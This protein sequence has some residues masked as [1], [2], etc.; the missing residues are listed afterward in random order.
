MSPVLFSLFL[1][2]LSEFISHAYNGLNNVSDMAHI[3]LSNDE[4]EVYFKLYILLYAD[5]TLIFAES[6]E[7]LQAAL[8]AM[9]LYCKSWDLE[10][11]P[12]KT[13]ITIFCNRK[14][15]HVPRFLHNGQ[16]LSVDDSFIYL[17]A[18]FSYNGHFTR[19]NQHLFDQAR[20]AMFSVLKKSR[21]LLLPIDIQL[22]MFDTMVLPILLYGSE[23]T[24]FEIHSML[25]R[26]CLQ[27]YKI[28]LNVK[29]KH[30]KFNFVWRTRKASGLS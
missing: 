17:G 29:K 9:F 24:G 1:N 11:N 22:Q 12:T 13:K 23:V 5:D 20:K 6:A 15:E 25:E 18:M 8:N 27:F 21:K 3:L 4:I 28:I 14:S 26:L 30:S 7:E 16:E 10:V 2:D 19:N